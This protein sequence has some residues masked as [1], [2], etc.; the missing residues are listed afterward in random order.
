MVI[1]SMAKKTATSSTI[2]GAP[3]EPYGLASYGINYGRL[4]TFLDGV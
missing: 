4:A 3:T 2:P 1:N